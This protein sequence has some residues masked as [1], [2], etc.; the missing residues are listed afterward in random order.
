MLIRLHHSMSLD[1]FSADTSGKPVILNMGVD[2][3]ASY[4]HPE[5]FARCAAVVVGRTTFDPALGAPRWPWPGKRVYVLTSRPVPATP[6][7]TDVEVCPGGPA[8]VVERLRASGSTGDVHLLG[9]PGTLRQF[10]EA[11]V[12]D[13]LEILVLP[14]LLGT[15]TPLFPLGCKEDRLELVEHV[16]YPDGTVKLCYRL[17]R[18]PKRDQDAVTVN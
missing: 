10:Y 6:A 12:I 17:R 18:A 3:A 11:G 2:P 9:G 14:F 5:F 1:G 13:R 8:E 4:G 15:G 16:A 7:G